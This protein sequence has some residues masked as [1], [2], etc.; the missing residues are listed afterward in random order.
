MTGQTSEIDG[1]QMDGECSPRDR[2]VGYKHPVGSVA[3][4]T[5]M[6]P[7]T[8][9]I[10]SCTNLQLRQRFRCIVKLMGEQPPGRS[11]RR[12]TAASPDAADSR[13]PRPVCNCPNAKTHN[14]KQNTTD[15]TQLNDEY[16]F[17]A[18]VT[19]GR[20]YCNPRS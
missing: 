11:A 1:E 12:T 15:V 13:Y 19:R 20:T 6:A 16:A 3:A 17:R 10:C 5:S 14:R 8:S 9:R 18:A 4:K 7:L 2:A